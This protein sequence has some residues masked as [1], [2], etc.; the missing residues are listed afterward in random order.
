MAG[1]RAA[2]GG[3]KKNQLAP[4]RSNITRI[5][6]PKEL[7]GDMAVAC[8][9]SASKILIEREIFEPED[10]LPLMM[11]C[12]AFQTVCDADQVI[13]EK[14]LTDVGG[15]GGLKVHPAVTVRSGAMAQLAR[16]GSLLGLDPMSRARM[17]G[18]GGGK[19]GEE[20]NEFDG[21]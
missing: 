4:R 5:A 1:V 7:R 11:Y 8:W 21:F 6:P 10:A 17:T 16:F 2:G 20:P 15:T 12:M 14:G 18:G 13:A 3:R 19:G 9:K